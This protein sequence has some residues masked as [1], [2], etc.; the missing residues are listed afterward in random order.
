M[1][2]TVAAA[3]VAG[4]LVVGVTTTA[5]ASGVANPGPVTL[6]IVNGSGVVTGTSMSF[7]VDGIST[8][9]PSFVD[10]NGDFTLQGL[11]F[12]TIPTD[13]NGTPG[14]STPVQSGDWQGNVNPDSGL[15]TITGDFFMSLAF[16]API[17]DATSSWAPRRCT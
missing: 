5:G 6:N 10:S 15:V 12:P 3:L 16:G 8:S 11:T 2:A 7:T 9:G 1:T 17:N 4:T 13:F 14:E